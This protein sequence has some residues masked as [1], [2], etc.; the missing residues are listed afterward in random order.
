MPK[1]VP[2][3]HDPFAQG[4]SQ[5]KLIPVDHDPFSTAPQGM[6]E[7]LGEATGSVYR[8][9]AKRG[10]GLIQTADSITGGN[11]LSGAQREAAQRFV[12]GLDRESNKQGG[13]SSTVGELVGDPINWMNPKGG[14]IKAAAKAGAA[15]ALTE[16][17]TEDKTIAD[18]AIDS[19]TGAA[20]GA[21]VGAAFK[22]VGKV[23]NKV[24]DDVTRL[25]PSG[26]K[27]S[28]ALRS[29]ASPL[30]EKFRQSGGV[31]TSNLTDE[32][33]GIAD[34]SKIKGI[35]GGELKPTDKA[36]NDA[37]DY[38]AGLRGKTLSPEDLQRLD[39]SLADDVSRFNRAG[40][41]NYG[42]ILNDLKYQL[43]DRAF[44]PT[45]APKYVNGAPPQAIKDLQEANRL[46][47]QSYKAADIEKILQKSM[48]TQT[49]GTSIRT[50]LKNLLANDKKMAGYSE[51]E[52]EL[53]K[54]AMDRGT[55]GG[56]INLFGGRATDAMAGGVAGFSAFGPIGALAGAAAGKAVG[57]GMAEAA[58][59]VQTNRLRNAL[60]TIQS[61]GK[62]APNNIPTSPMV[63]SV[64]RK[65]AT[66]SATGA[67][68]PSEQPYREPLRIDIP[69]LQPEPLS[70]LS[71]SSGLVDRIAQTES[72]GD[73]NAKN[74]KGSASGLLQFTDPTWIK[75]VARYGK[76]TGITLKDKSNPEAQKVMGELL[77]RDNG[78]ILSKQIGREPT[79][80]ELYAAHFLGASD[81][82]KLIN[83]QGTGKQAKLLFSP[84]VVA[85]NKSIFY[86]G[87][88]PRT[89]EG[90]L[91]ILTDK[92]S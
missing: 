88:K 36:F 14:I 53:L 65:A 24:Y 70:Q 31:Y 29:E 79:D 67:A 46:W 74:P 35:A 63:D 34:A 78:R 83:A 81:A 11:I 16:G 77:A 57:G 64:L 22:G 42:R 40:E 54:K 33:A 85:D 80:G 15:S 27:T 51:A 23:A 73:P 49:P 38:Y 26:A 39:Q 21:A 68:P 37:L 87:K 18:R 17:S 3:D 47:S 92:V 90:V 12:G 62:Y 89:V 28:K 55:I 72:G 1:Y 56:L 8:G 20:T 4:N 45:N 41:Y 69:A 30:F 19:A 60:E 59:K 32:L 61:G 43:R 86:D 13:I 7:S 91:S 76:Q 58:G 6:L 10:A 50:G 82:V 9:L 71:P 44:N 5:P 52:K 2:V 84:K 66:T 75:M 48:G 25:L